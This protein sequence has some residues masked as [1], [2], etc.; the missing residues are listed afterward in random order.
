MKRQYC[1]HVMCR[2]CMQQCSHIASICHAIVVIG[3]VQLSSSSSL[4]YR[5]WFLKHHH[6]AAMPHHHRRCWRSCRTYENCMHAEQII[7]IF[8]I[9]FILFFALCVWYCSQLYLYRTIVTVYTDNIFLYIY[10]QQMHQIIHLSPLGCCTPARGKTMQKN[11]EVSRVNIH[12]VTIRIVVVQRWCD[13][14]K[15]IT[16]WLVRV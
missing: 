2:T 7:I 9:Y 16:N 12:C 13:Y 8:Y 3:C 5:L 1:K 15:L 4:I 6:S 11:W 10:L 14:C